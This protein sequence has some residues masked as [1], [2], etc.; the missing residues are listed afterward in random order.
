MC[1]C[2]LYKIVL[3]ILSRDGVIVDEVCIGYRIYCTLTQLIPTLHNSLLHT[4][5]NADSH[6]FTAVAW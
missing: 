3:K 5:T 2:Q 4:H 6:V 1:Q